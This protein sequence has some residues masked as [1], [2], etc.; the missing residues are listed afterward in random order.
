MFSV[1]L[2]RAKKFIDALRLQN[3]SIV[4]WLCCTTISPG[5]FYYLHQTMYTRFDKALQTSLLMGNVQITD[6]NM[7]KI[8]ED[9]L[10]KRG[11]YTLQVHVLQKPWNILLCS[12]NNDN[13]FAIYFAIFPIER[14][15][16]KVEV[17][18]RFSELIVHVAFPSFFF[19]LCLFLC[20]LIIFR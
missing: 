3:S 1:E 8:Q 11:S 13:D 18:G 12:T 6:N 7:Q 16:R 2:S 20:W 4:I 9:L 10:C 14:Y 15:V 5:T 17:V 19:K